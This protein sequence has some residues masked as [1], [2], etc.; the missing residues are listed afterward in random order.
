MIQFRDIK[1]LVTISVLLFYIWTAFKSKTYCDDYYGVLN[2]A[3]D[4]SYDSIIDQNGQIN[5]IEVDNEEKEVHVNFDDGRTFV[6]YIHENER[7]G[8]IRV[9]IT[10]D[11]YVFGKRK[12]SIESNRTEIEKIYRKHERWY[13]TDDWINVIDGRYQIAFHFTDDIVSKIV[14]GYSD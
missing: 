8:L 14:V 3:D 9:E 4:L 10:S 12:V 6:F 7:R 2:H 13:V 5:D 1:Y 11:K